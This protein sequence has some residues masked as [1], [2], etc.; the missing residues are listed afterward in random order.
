M[1]VREV[2]AIAVV[3]VAIGVPAALAASEVVRGYLFQ[4]KPND[5]LAVGGA[6]AAMLAAA[7]AAGY[8]PAWR[9]SK[10][11]PWTALRDE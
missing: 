2:L 5:P 9:A 1:V 7:I 10:I 8:W 3:G 11:D 6:A 4:M